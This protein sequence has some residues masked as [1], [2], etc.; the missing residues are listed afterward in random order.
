MPHWVTYKTG[1]AW[2]PDEKLMYINGF[3]WK[4]IL[5]ALKSF[6]KTSLRHVKIKSD[7]TPAIHCIKRMSSPSSNLSA[8]HIS[9]KL[10]TVT[11][12]ESRSNHVDTEWMLQSKFLIRELVHLGF[13]PEIDLLLPILTHSLANMQHLGQ[14]Q[15]Q[16]I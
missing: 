14:I 16:C 13:K 3:E 12:M 2:F 10:N 6:V 1:E 9:R 5:L 11:V 15:G 7:N 8:A 4:A